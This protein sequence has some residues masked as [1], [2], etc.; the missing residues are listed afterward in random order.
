MN[1]IVLI[2]GATGGIGEKI[3]LEFGRKNNVV[4]IVYKNNLKKAEKLLKTVISN[5]SDGEIKR[6]DISNE[7]DVKELVHYVK[8]KFGRVDVLINNAGI[9]RN[10]II[11]NMKEEDWDEVINVNLKGVFLFTKEVCK[12]MIKQKEG[13]IINIGS[14]CGLKGSFGQSNYSASKAALIGF[15]KSL[16]KEM[17]IFNIKINLVF[18]GFHRTN[19]SK[20]LSNEKIQKIIDRHVLGKTSS[21]SEVSK[22][23]Y[24]LSDLKT[25][26]GQI[27]NLDSR[28]I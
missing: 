11:I 27:F 7:K 28:I 10:S 4:I 15:T 19:I 23:I 25:I 22:F 24:F 8:N 21:L 2:T 17:G 16:A 1:K 5:G 13:C 3:T 18:P 14:I 6:V 9:L 20:D 26:S 12:V